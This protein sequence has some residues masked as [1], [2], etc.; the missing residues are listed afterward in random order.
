M[1]G[2]LALLWDRSVKCRRDPTLGS[3]WTCPHVPFIC[4]TR[5][6]IGLWPMPE[7]RRINITYFP[8]RCG[9]CDFFHLTNHFFFRPLI[10]S[11]SKY[12]QALFASWRPMKAGSRLDVF[13]ACCSQRTAWGGAAVALLRV[14]TLTATATGDVGALVTLGNW[15]TRYCPM[16]PQE[17]S[18]GT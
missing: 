1:Y 14:H 2:A 12:Q 15:I 3:I 13:H 9:W 16:T 18:F 4:V 8:P 17:R 5:A 11:E 6:L 10:D 7:F